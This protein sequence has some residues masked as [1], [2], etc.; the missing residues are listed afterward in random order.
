MKSVDWSLC[1]I[2]DRGSAGP[3]RSLPD[4]ARAA[5]AGGATV[6]QLR[7]KAGPTRA[8]VRCQVASPPR[9]PGW[10]TLVRRLPAWWL[11]ER[12][13]RCL[14]SRRSVPTVFHP[15]MPRVPAL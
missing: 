5:A 2:I 9:A 8:T 15:A 10:P 1:V 12:A 11:R 3:E 4:L 6:L 13:R 7:A 14:P